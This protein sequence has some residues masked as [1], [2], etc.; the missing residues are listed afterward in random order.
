MQLPS[1]L[2]LQNQNQI[3]SKIHLTSQKKLFA[4]DAPLQKDLLDNQL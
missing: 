2:L 1:Q 4:V 3:K